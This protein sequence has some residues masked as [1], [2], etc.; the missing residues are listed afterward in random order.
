MAGGGEPR[1]V[2]AVVL[3]TGVT[4]G[5]VGSAAGIVCGFAVARIAYPFLNGPFNRAVGLFEISPRVIFGS[6]I[7]GVAAATLAAYAPARMAGKLTVIQALAART[8]PPKPPASLVRIGVLLVTSGAV[9]TTWSMTQHQALIVVLGMLMML[10]GFFLFIPGLVSLL[11]R[12]ANLLPLSGR[13]AARDSSRHGRRTA[14]AIAAAVVALSLP[15]ALASHLLSEE[16]FER[17][18]PAL[19]ENQLQIGTVRRFPPSATTAMTR[20]LNQAFPSA[21]TAALSQ[22]YDGRIEGDP[23][24]EPVSA[25][26]LKHESER[27]TVRGGTL[28]IGGE[29]LLRAAGAEG[30][31]DLSLRGKA[32]VLQGYEPVHGVLTVPPP[33]SARGTGEVRLPAIS[34]DSPKLAN[35]SLPVVVISPDT[36][37]SLGFQE[38]T[39]GYLISTPAAFSP[40]DIERARNIVQEYPGFYVLSED[41]YLPPFGMARTISTTASMGIALGLLAVVVA[42]V[43]AESRRSHQILVAIGS[44]PNMH[45]RI[46]AATS[47]LLALI[48]SVLAIPA[49][50]VPTWVVQNASGAGRPLAIPWATMGIVLVV[51]PILASVCAGL[52]ARPPKLGSL[53]RLSD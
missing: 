50:L 24:G 48:A 33:S 16:K 19:L 7:M 51:T 32:V 30:I 52:F 39:T 53:L 25:F 26:G 18:T 41:D 22:A 42:L 45:R 5:F 23:Q 35:E 34:V 38:V 37:K 8:P 44:G 9:V 20:V 13:Q 46:V 14:A 4:L 1:H 11:G 27:K 31:S 12:G 49:G 29:E 2:R 15:I 10:L 43:V 47:G 17:Q 40:E 21:T 3:M 6:F 36:A 28:Y